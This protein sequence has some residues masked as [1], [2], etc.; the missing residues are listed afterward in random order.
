MD[1]LLRVSIPLGLGLVE[2]NTSD[3]VYMAYQIFLDALWVAQIISSRNIITN[4]YLDEAVRFYE[5]VVSGA[6]DHPANLDPTILQDDIV[7][8]GHSLGGIVAGYL[9]G[10]TGN[11]V[12]TFASGPHEN[13][14]RDL[15]QH[16]LREDPSN[17]LSGVQVTPQISNLRLDGEILGEMVALAV[18]LANDPVGFADAVADLLFLSIDPRHAIF[19]QALQPVAQALQLRFGFADVVGTK[20]P[21]LSAATSG[22]SSTDLHSMQLHGVVIYAEENLG[23]SNYKNVPGFLSGLFDEEISESTGSS[24]NLTSY[25]TTELRSEIVFVAIG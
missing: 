14:L 1:E 18:G 24:F 10:I 6:F 9:G 8:S 3:P 15:D 4:S 21:E 23:Y 20:L 17:F 11:Q 25:S 2:G 12:M 19:S 7:F 13:V 22:L 16:V 5:S